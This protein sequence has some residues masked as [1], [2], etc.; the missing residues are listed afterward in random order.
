[1]AKQKSV[2]AKI[3][4][5]EYREVVMPYPSGNQYFITYN[6][7]KDIRT[8]WMQVPEGYERLATDDTPIALYEKVA[9]LEGR[10]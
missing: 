7:A 8:L 5:T 10:S 1:M 6:S 2:I 9:A 4:D 3:P